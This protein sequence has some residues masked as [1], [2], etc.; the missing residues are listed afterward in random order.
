MKPVRIGNVGNTHD[1]NIHR[2]GDRQRGENVR[3]RI[4]HMECLVNRHLKDGGRW[5]YRAIDRPMNALS[6]PPA[7]RP[8]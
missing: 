3:D 1:V 5:I 8:E 2:I 7:A 4:E 6:I